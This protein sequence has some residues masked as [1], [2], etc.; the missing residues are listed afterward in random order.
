MIF[1]IPDFEIGQHFPFKNKSAPEPLS[2]FLIDSL[3]NFRKNLFGID[4]FNNSQ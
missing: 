4:K 1:P 2:G 3:K